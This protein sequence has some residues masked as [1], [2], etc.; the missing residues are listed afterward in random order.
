MTEEARRQ[1]WEHM[2]SCRMN[3]LYHTRMAGEEYRE[4]HRT[5]AALYSF[6]HWVFRLI[7]TYRD[8]SLLAKARAGYARVEEWE[9]EQEGPPEEA[10][11]G[12]AQEMAQREAAEE[13][14][15]A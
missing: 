10:V 4:P 3:E 2:L 9:A 14:G 15:T 8:Y 7:F 13:F 6:L 5:L 12:E 11:L 1:A